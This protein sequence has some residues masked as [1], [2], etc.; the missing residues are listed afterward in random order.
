MSPFREPYDPATDDSGTHRMVRRVYEHFAVG[1][2][3]TLLL[4]RMMSRGDL[5]RFVK[6]ENFKVLD[7]AL[8]KGRGAGTTC[9]RSRA[10][11]RI[12]SWTPT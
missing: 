7:E 11:S 6:M 5:D 2:I 10:R 8:A 1:A 9:R 3:E 4:P 12:R